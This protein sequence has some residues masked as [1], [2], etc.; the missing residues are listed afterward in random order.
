[1]DHNLSYWTMMAEECDEHALPRNFS[2]IH[3][4]MMDDFLHERPT[5]EYPHACDFQWPH[6]E[7]DVSNVDLLHPIGKR[8]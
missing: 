1:M 4:E 3:F 2:N 6:K 8:L 7:Y 5:I